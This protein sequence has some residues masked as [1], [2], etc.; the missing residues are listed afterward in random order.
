MSW[1][2]GAMLCNPCQIYLIWHGLHKLNATYLC[3][4][5]YKNQIIYVCIECSRDQSWCFETQ[6]N[7]K[8]SNTYVY[9]MSRRIIRLLVFHKL[10]VEIE[11]KSEKYPIVL[12]QDSCSPH[13]RIP[14]FVDH[15]LNN[16]PLV[17]SSCDASHPRWSQLHSK[18]LRAPTLTLLI[19]SQLHVCC[20]L[21]FPTKTIWKIIISNHHNCKK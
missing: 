5:L 4:L 1:D 20:P 13:I 3:M 18:N 11:T 7:I 14:R 2:L 9:N 15:H 16:N 10:N 17:W 8:F 6:T 19:A 12:V 21:V